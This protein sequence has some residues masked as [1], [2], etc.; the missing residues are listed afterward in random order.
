MALLSVEWKLRRLY[1]SKASV[2]V[3]MYDVGALL[4][5]WLIPPKA[6]RNQKFIVCSA[7]SISTIGFRGTPKD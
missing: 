5:P 6:V 1:A 2:D 4:D 7:I 3:A